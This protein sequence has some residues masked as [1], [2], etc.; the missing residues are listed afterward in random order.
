[1]PEIKLNVLIIGCGKIAGGFDIGQDKDHLPVTHAGSY[2]HD[3]RFTIKA[4]IDPDDTAREQFM[5]YWGIPTGYRSIDDALSAGLS[6]NIVSVCSPTNRHMNDVLAAINLHPQLIFCEKPVTEQHEKTIKLLD[7]CEKAGI[8]LAVNHNRR[9][10]P[11]IR[12]LKQALIEEKYG[13]LRSVV[14]FYNKG[15]LNNGS[16]L[17]DLLHYLLGKMN[18]LATGKGFI[19]LTE[20]DP[21]IPALLCSEKGVN[22]H[23]V[24]GNAKDFSLFELQFIFSDAE[25][26]MRDGGTA[27]SCRY[28]KESSRFSGYQ[29][30]GEAELKPGGY[31]YTMI[32]AIENIYETL[33]KGVKLQSSGKTAAQAQDVCERI[34]SSEKELNF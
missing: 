3:G 9:W 28:K 1:M 32:H 7:A 20:N 6:I 29:I 19:D 27:W 30:L 16:H 17:I 21:T 10:D 11:E 14:G 5:D 24:T 12:R 23:L 13:Q 22:I 31:Q 8:I 33:S 18:I 25:L 4:C 34:I 15:I 26:V 2:L